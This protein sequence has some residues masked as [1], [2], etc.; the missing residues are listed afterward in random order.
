MR[1]YLDMDIGVKIAHGGRFCNDQEDG[2]GQ[3]RDE[4]QDECKNLKVIK[5]VSLFH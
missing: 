1:R 4:F 5:F 2:G 3:L